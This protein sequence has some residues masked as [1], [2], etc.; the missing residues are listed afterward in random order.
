MLVTLVRHSESTN[1]TLA[2]SCS[3]DRSKFET[4]RSADPA[5][6]DRGVLQAERVGARIADENADASVILTSF[7]HR[8]LRTAA[9]IELAFEARHG[10][11]PQVIVERDFHEAGGHY[12]A[13]ADDDASQK[14]ATPSKVASDGSDVYA[15]PGLRFVGTP[16]RTA[17]QV[18]DEFP[19]FQVRPEQLCESGWWRYEGKEPVASSKR[20]ARDVWQRLAEYAREGHQSIVVVTHGHLYALMM[21]EAVAAGWLRHDHPAVDALQNTG[22]TRVRLEQQT[23]PPQQQLQ[24]PPTLNTAAQASAGESGSAHV[25][26]RIDALLFNCGAHV[27]DIGALQSTAATMVTATD[28]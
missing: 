5:L 20:R 28:G 17:K 21:L 22:V 6:T 18:T 1:N 26:L 24:E 2:A 16:G 19:T 11:R 12:R 15:G 9:A 10:R 25:P 13:G 23:P 14:C 4:G 8:A 7:L 27:D 3:N